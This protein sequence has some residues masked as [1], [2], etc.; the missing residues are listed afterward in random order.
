[1]NRYIEYTINTDIEYSI[2]IFKFVNGYF[3]SISEG[4]DHKLGYLSISVPNISNPLMTDNILAKVLS[5]HISDITNK[6]CIVSVNAKKIN[7]IN[8][9]KIFDSVMEYIR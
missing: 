7:T 9:K 5:Q 4:R 8:M 3:I 2:L 1:M 6:L